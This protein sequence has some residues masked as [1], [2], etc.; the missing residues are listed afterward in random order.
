[1]KCGVWRHRLWGQVARVCLQFG[2]SLHCSPARDRPVTLSVC[3][4]L[5][6]SV[7][8]DTNHAFLELLEL[9][10]EWREW[11][12]TKHLEECAAHS[13]H[14]LFISSDSVAVG[15]PRGSVVKNPP[16]SVEGLASIPGS[17]RV[18]GGGNS[19]PLQYSCLRSLVGYSLWGHEES[20][21][22]EQ[23]NRCR[24]VTHASVTCSVWQ[25]TG[26]NP[27]RKGC[28]YYLLTSITI[29]NIFTFCTLP[30]KG[31]NKAAPQ[32]VLPMLHLGQLWWRFTDV[33]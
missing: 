33:L 4:S 11:P 28:C 20:D 23:L 26:F 16:A 32:V 19:S 18:T 5:S 24:A 22:T 14:Y 2:S 3:A 9:L 21:T 25:D 13:K 15:F 17:G 8:T 7:D 10:W 6:S 1:M 31:S 27:Q 29:I 30:L 12:C